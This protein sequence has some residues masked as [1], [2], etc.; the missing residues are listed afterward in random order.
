MHPTYFQILLVCMTTLSEK[1]AAAQMFFSLIFCAMWCS[2]RRHSDFLSKK[3]LSKNDSKNLFVQTHEIWWSSFAEILGHW[4]FTTL[5]TR[6]S[7]CNFTAFGLALWND[8]HFLLWVHYGRE[9]WVSAIVSM[10][11]I[12]GGDLLVHHHWSK[13]ANHFSNRFVVHCFLNF[14]GDR[15]NTEK[16]HNI[17]RVDCAD[18][19]HI[20]RQVSEMRLRPLR[21][22]EA[23]AGV[24]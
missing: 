22:L 24:W 4:V 19:A 21:L 8:G 7:F 18:V 17:T 11:V 15:K 13:Y 12:K 3:L 1:F 5:M 9:Q 20:F 6:A 10:R 14:Q 2:V 16:F 23:A